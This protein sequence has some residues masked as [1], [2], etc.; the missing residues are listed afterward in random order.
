MKIFLNNFWFERP[1][2]TIT[3]SVSEN[4]Y[5]Q[6]IIECYYYKIIANSLVENF[7]KKFCINNTFIYFNNIKLDPKKTILYYNIKNNNNL[8]IKSLFSY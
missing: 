8:T 6:D 3:L 5:I 1:F 2:L 7:S 4:D